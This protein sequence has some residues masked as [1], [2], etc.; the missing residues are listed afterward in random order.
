VLYT[1]SFILPVLTLDVTHCL[2]TDIHDVSGSDST[3]E[4]SHKPLSHVDS[5]QHDIAITNWLFS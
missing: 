4:V 3:A 1:Q 2:M 5:F